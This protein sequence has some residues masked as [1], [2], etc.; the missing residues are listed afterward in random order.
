MAGDKINRDTNDVVLVNDFEEYLKKRYAK[1]N[2]SDNEIKSIIRDILDNSTSS[3]YESNKRFIKKLSD[4]IVLKRSNKKKD[5]LIELIDYA[6]KDI[7][8]FKIVSQLEIRGFETRIPDLILYVNGLP[9][10]IFEFK[11]AIREN[12]TLHD[13]YTQLSIRYKRDI[14]EIFKYN[15]FCVI[16]DGVNTKMSSIFSPYEFFYSWRKI[17]EKD[18]I[19]KDGIDHCFQ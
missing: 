17:S 3:L 4:G 7:N 5:I 10:V 18:Q 11:S 6:D 1:D 19:Q 13:A 8:N 15:A 12:A 16:S 9:L 14:P 2:I